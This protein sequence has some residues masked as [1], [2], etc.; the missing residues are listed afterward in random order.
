MRSLLALLSAFSLLPAQKHYRC[1]ALF[2]SPSHVTRHAP[3]P[4][5]LRA[6][7]P[8]L[9]ATTSVAPPAPA[10]EF[11]SIE[12]RT[13]T[14]LDFAYV[15]ECLRNAT[16]TVLGADIAAHRE[17]RTVAEA[18]QAYAMVDELSPH[19]GYVPLRTSMNVWPILRAIEMNTAP[20][21]RD[22]L[23]SFAEH[24]ESL[25]EVR[26]YFEANLERLPLFIDLAAQVR[27]PAVS[28]ACVRCH[29][30]HHSSSWQLGLPEELAAAFK[31]SF[32]DEG[33][34]NADKYP[35]LGRLRRQAEALRGRI[36]QVGGNAP[37]VPAPAPAVSP[38]FCCS[39]T[40]HVI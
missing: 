12:E 20:P 1:T 26:V 7:A 4:T 3:L 37:M 39:H 17:A 29:R 13:T 21:E 35:E 27:G 8:T 16:V 38:T 15:L 18:T 30:P 25:D 24:V 33:N 6:Y 34:L 40:Y 10:L 11:V 36:V 28:A 14:C 2:L 22:D 32:D 23:A 19:I 9:T 31:G 5:T